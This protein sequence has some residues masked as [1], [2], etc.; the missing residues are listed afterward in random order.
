VRIDIVTHYWPP[1]AA[2]GTNRM[3]GW[4]ET[5]RDAGHDI[6]V[7][8][9]APDAGDPF[10]DGTQQPPH[11]IVT[12]HVPLF[13]LGARWRRRPAAGTAEPA[14]HSPST[15]RRAAL[16]VRDLLELPDHRRLWNPRLRR[17]MRAAEP[18]DVLVTTS[19]YNS[20][21][22]VGLD[23]RRRHPQGVWVADFRDPW[24]QP[25]RRH[26]ATP[27]HRHLALQHE[28]AIARH[29]DLLTFWDTAG[30]ADMEARIGSAVADKALGVWNGLA[31]DTLQELARQAVAPP[32]SPPRIIYAGT[33][34]DWRLPPGLGAAW[35]AFAA[36][37][38][39]P[40]ELCFVGRVEP[41]AAAALEACRRQAPSD[42]PIRVLPPV[43]AAEALRLQSE[44]TALLNLASPTPDTLTS[45]LFEMIALRRPILFVGHP[46]SPGAAWLRELGAD[47]SV[48]AGWNEDATTRLF[49]DFGAA[50]ARRD[51][52]GWQPHSVPPDI[53]RTVQARRLL[54]RIEM[55]AAD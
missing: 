24:T 41:A 14:S 44:A 29:A 50:L 10:Y 40:A 31:A 18:A 39:Q 45:K 43:T 53:D 34:W 5:W 21:H 13:D 22:L 15:A 52:A 19:P 47:R 16:A 37:F 6:R 46:D 11:G 25:W 51:L 3:L 35:A 12:V 23:W 49:A 36:A 54:R 2:P 38:G 7:W 20:T 4:A 27:F 8:T 42:A 26:I 30:I 55:L 9:P 32:V 28:R 33:L 1:I 48:A 17:A